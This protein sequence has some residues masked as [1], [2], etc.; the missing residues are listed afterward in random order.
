MANIN[1]VMIEDYHYGT[2]EVSKKILAISTA[3]GITGR[4]DNI[5]KFGSEARVPLELRP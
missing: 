2:H 3:N 1:D 5:F 4:F